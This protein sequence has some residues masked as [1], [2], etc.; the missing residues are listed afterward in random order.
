MEIIIEEAKFMNPVERKKFLED[1]CREVKQGK[2]FQKHTEEE[3]LVL[4]EQLAEQAIVIAE[5]QEHFKTV[6]TQLGGEI[7]TL[8][9][10]QNNT[11]SAIRS[12]GVMKEGDTYMFDDQKEGFMYFYDVN[13]NLLDKRK[14]RPDEKQIT[15]H[16]SINKERLGDASAK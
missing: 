16:S 4:K 8:V 12:K 1:N 13:G 15:M 14:L 7:K 9:E 11:L 6:K 2:Y 10:E 5:K 3:T